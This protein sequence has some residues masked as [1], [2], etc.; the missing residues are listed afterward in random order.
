MN[1]EYLIK[2]LK[3][4][5]WET[6]GKE[7]KDLRYISS[8]LLNHA[9]HHGIKEGRTLKFDKNKNFLKHKDVELAE[10]LNKLDKFF[11]IQPIHG[12]SNRLR[13]IASAYSICKELNKT[14]II[15]WIPD[16]HCDC[17][18]ED[19]IT[20]ID[21]L[22]V[23]VIDNIDT[24]K[25]MKLGV[26]F[27]RNYNDNPIIDHSKKKL[28][29]ESNNIL[30]NEH[31]NTHMNK[32]YDL[33]RPNVNVT[34]KHSMKYGKITFITSL[35]NCD[36]YIDNYLKS[37][38]KINNVQYH[39]IFIWNVID[40]NKSCT[41]KKIEDFC[42]NKEYITLIQKKKK[43]DYGLYSSWNIMFDLVDTEFICNLNADDKLHPSFCINAIDK[44]KKYPNMDVCIF[45]S[46]TS[47]N[48]NNQFGDIDLPQIYNKLQLNSNSNNED[49]ISRDYVKQ[50]ILGKKIQYNWIDYGNFL[51][52]NIFNLFRFEK[53]NVLLC[54]IF[55]CCPI[56]KKKLIHQFGK[57][58][59]K[60][61]GPS[62]DA[63]YFLKLIYNNINVKIFNEPMSLY[64]INDNSYSR[65]NIKKKNEC[66][67][68]IINLY[69]PYKELNKIY[70]NKNKMYD[71]YF[72][73]CETRINIKKTDKSEIYYYDN[74]WQY[75]VITE[76]RAFELLK[77]E[78]LPINYLAFPWATLIDKC[79]NNKDLE[80]FK[81]IGNL[82]CKKNCFT[83]CQHI[84]F[85]KLLPIFKNIGITHL[86]ASHTSKYDY[87][88]EELY[89]I[90][91]IPFH[92]Y[93]FNSIE[94]YNL[95][96]K[97]LKYIYSFEGAYNPKCYLKSRSYLKNINN[98]KYYIHI[99]NE[100]NFQKEVY[101]DQIKNNVFVSTN[102][103]KLDTDYI[104]LLESSQFTLCPSGSGPNSIRFWEALSV[105]SIPILLSDHLL[106]NQEIEWEKY[107]II[108]EEKKFSNLN[109]YIEKIPYHRIQLMQNN[110]IELFNSM[111]SKTNF[112]KPILLYD[113]QTPNKT[114][115]KYILDAKQYL[116]DLSN[117]IKEFIN[118]ETYILLTQLYFETDKIKR[119]EIS[120]CILLNIEN[121]LIEMIVIFFET[122]EI[123]DC[124]EIYKMYPQLK[125]PKVVIE[126]VQVKFPKSININRIIEYSNRFIGSKCIISNNDIYYDHTLALIKKGKLLQ[127]N[128]IV[129]LTRTNVFEMKSS[130]TGV[131]QKHDASQDTWIYTSPIKSIKND[132]YLGWIRSDNLFAGELY[133]L[134]YRLSNPTN[135]IN[136]FHYQ[137]DNVTN[138]SICKNHIHQQSG[139]MRV[140]FSEVHKISK[141][142][143]IWQ[144]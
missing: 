3:H 71:H 17:R 104:K 29:V 126:I 83:I 77:D 105:G 97:K 66:D 60:D 38:E 81:I 19:L 44:F 129:C 137:H 1:K 13:A 103:E 32:F 86:F 31:S 120:H 89:G 51:D 50:T 63:E 65:I 59:E 42:K 40:S 94:N 22:C 87:M 56:F 110:C 140:G 139:C 114:D 118:N 4:W 55:G 100:W 117:P 14:L 111:F 23:L 91:I 68:K 43:D 85:R 69:N 125:H 112:V 37:I 34:K 127:N 53:N 92:L 8:S 2:N 124:K 52:V 67:D 35:Y 131:W 133:R 26:T 41:N 49:D 134:G 20:N 122:I 6:Y 57:I 99:K 84:H 47:K 62:A 10:Y 75:P 74:E 15:N 54:N 72:M 7:N 5:D 113:W 70:I 141:C 80:L 76:K 116:Q 88:Y 79:N 102:D 90:K 138:A 128:E 18:I 108:W 48:Y 16:C 36:I 98:D 33:Y 25:L 12:L 30:N 73:D 21:D 27:Q 61:Y 39:K 142:S 123:I 109:E 115:P 28:Y 144:E 24:N 143:L 64:Y 78:C 130:T 106:L 45:T 93:P 101:V 82:V 121:K 136:A 107:I 96:H 119:D 9:L 46:Y 11:I 58:N 135:Y 95:K 132:V